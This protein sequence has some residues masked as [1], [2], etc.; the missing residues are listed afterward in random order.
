MIITIKK[1]FIAKKYRKQ[2]NQYSHLMS[3]VMTLNCIWWW[4]SSFGYLVFVEYLFI[5]IVDRSILILS[6]STC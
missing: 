4:N 3:W 1:I 2:Q 5:V 6:D